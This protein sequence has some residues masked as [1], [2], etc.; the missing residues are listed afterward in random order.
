MS[1]GAHHVLSTLLFLISLHTGFLND[2]GIKTQDLVENGVAILI[3]LENEKYDMKPE[4]VLVTP[5]G[6]ELRKLSR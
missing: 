3:F 1:L 6:L 4:F 5:W 2:Q